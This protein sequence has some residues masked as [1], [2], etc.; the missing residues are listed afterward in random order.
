[1]PALAADIG[2]AMRDAQVA[3]IDDS[4]IKDRFPGARDGKES[5][6]E[7]FFDLVNEAEDCLIGRSALI[8]ALRRRFAVSVA[9]MMLIDIAGGVPTYHLIDTQHGV[10]TPC[11]VARIEVDTEAETTSMELFG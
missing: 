6:A 11:L 8:G 4:T 3:T 7:G 1:M 2:P 5:P 10:D 9:E